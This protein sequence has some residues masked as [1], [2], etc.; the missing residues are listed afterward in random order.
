MKKGVETFTA[1]QAID[2]KRM[3]PLSRN[4]ETGEKI[5]KPAPRGEVGYAYYYA[6]AGTVNHRSYIVC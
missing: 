3:I 2:I 6:V 5:A 1:V 4:R